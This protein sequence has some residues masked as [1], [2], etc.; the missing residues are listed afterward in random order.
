M[1]AKGF[2]NRFPLFNLNKKSTQRAD[3]HGK[4]QKSIRQQ[5]INRPRGQRGG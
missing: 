3:L 5:K 4:L 2:S 1:C